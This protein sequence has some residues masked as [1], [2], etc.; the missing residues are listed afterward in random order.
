LNTGTVLMSEGENFATGDAVNVAARLEQAAM[1]GEIVIGSETLGLVRDAVVAEALEPLELKG[2]SGRVA[3]FR[4]VSVDPV[5]PGV[6]RRFDSALV[7]REHELALLGEAW[8]R[9]V[10]ESGCHLF[11]LLGMAGVGKSRLVVEL[12]ERVGDQAIALRGR[13]LP[14][15]EGI[16]FWPLVEALMPV[17]ERA[18]HVLERLTVGGAAVPQGAVLGCPAAARVTRVAAAGDPACR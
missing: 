2:K 7:G 6:A 14:Y 17:G 11:T 9:V 3:A 13:C 4:L 12:L 8:A 10:R 5:S 1:P 16:T 15:G 18:A